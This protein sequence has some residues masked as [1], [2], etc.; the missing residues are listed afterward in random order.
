MFI[1][2]FL[3]PF[4]A[5][6]LV[7]FDAGCSCSYSFNEED[8]APQVCAQI[9]FVGGR[10][11]VTTSDYNVTVSPDSSPA[12]ADSKPI[13]CSYIAIWDRKKKIFLK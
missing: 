12:T 8:G 9:L 11:S 13:S 6:V 4:S 2:V 10:E 1:L 3:L 7:W 5:E